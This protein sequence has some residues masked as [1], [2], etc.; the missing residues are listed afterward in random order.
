MNKLILAFALLTSCSAAQ[1]PKT[2]AVDF[3][4][5]YEACYESKHQKMPQE[6]AGQ[7]RVVANVN[8]SWRDACVAD[9]NN[10][11]PCAFMLCMQAHMTIKSVAAQTT[12][13][14]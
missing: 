3:C 2:N 12:G 13:G 9:C 6:L 8:D 4:N 7:C 10:L 11:P 5:K 14:M 1:F